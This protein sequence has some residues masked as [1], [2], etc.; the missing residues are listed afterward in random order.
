MS[1][2]KQA[3][4]L[5]IPLKQHG[6]KLRGYMCIAMYGLTNDNGQ[7]VDSIGAGL[8]TVELI[9]ACEVLRVRAITD[10]LRDK[11]NEKYATEDTLKQ[12]AAMPTGIE[13]E[14]PAQ[15]SPEVGDLF[16]HLANSQSATEESAE[17]PAAMPTGIEPEM[18][19]AAPVQEFPEV[20]DP[21]YRLASN[22]R[23]AIKALYDKNGTKPFYL[24]IKA[25]K[26][27]RHAFR[28]SD[29]ITTLKLLEKRGLVQMDDHDMTETAPKK[30]QFLF[31]MPPARA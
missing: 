10:T 20:A 5:N 9:G 28:V 14:A 6:L 25:H 8:S 30:V 27:L 1:T 23:S 4:Q 16:C 24:T 15:A 29:I 31:T 7:Y 2:K 22:T 13:P 21:F 3:Y 26:R 18:I 12:P 19:A 11:K 17:Q